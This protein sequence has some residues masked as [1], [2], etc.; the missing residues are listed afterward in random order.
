METSVENKEQDLDGKSPSIDFYIVSPKKAL[1]LFIGTFGIYSVYWF[2]KHWSQYKKSTNDDLWPVMRALFSI[3]F[4]HSLFALFEMKY[5]QKNGEPPKSIKHL[6]TIYVVFAVIGQVC[7]QLVE[8]GYNNPLTVIFS[9]LIIPISGWIIYK[10]Q[11]LA[12]YA[13]EDV[14]ASSNNKLTPINYLW[15]V[16]ISYLII[17]GVNAT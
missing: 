6:A 5:E 2:F 11:S 17:Q 10:T 15:I 9:V 1:I 4:V 7:T 13:G 12:N 3:F 8:N 16:V 14:H